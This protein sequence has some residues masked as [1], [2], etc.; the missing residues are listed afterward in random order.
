[1]YRFK[2]TFELMPEEIKHY[3]GIY[4][5]KRSWPLIIVFSVLT[6]ICLGGA[7]F[8]A[9]LKRNLLIAAILAA[10]AVLMFLMIFI[11]RSITKKLYIKKP[12]FALGPYVSIELSDGFLHVNCSGNMKSYPQG[13]LEMDIKNGSYILTRKKDI[14]VLP[15]RIL[16]SLIVGELAKFFSS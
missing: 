16:T 1:M 3:V 11:S 4:A 10:A 2:T 5:K 13:Y 14:V 6:A 15:R 12:P 9:A 7:I 8:S